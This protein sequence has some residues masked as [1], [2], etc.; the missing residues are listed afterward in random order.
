MKGHGNILDF[1]QR[2][3]RLILSGGVKLYLSKSLWD[4]VCRIHVGWGKTIGK[5]ASQVALQKKKNSWN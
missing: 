4:V 1:I 5:E 3:M 2:A